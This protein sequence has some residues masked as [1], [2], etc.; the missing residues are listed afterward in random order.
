MS[1]EELKIVWKC[2][3]CCTHSRPSSRSSCCSPSCERRGATTSSSSRCRRRRRPRTACATRTSFNRA[4]A[5]RGSPPPRPGRFAAGGRGVSSLLTQ[6]RWGWVC[7]G[8]AAAGSPPPRPGRFAAGGRGVSSLLTQRRWGWVC[9]GSAAAGLAAPR[10]GRFAAGGRGV[11]SL[12]TQRRWGWVCLGSAAP[13]PADQ[14]L[15]AARRCGWFS[16]AAALC[17]MGSRAAGL[18]ARWPW[19]LRGSRAWRARGPLTPGRSCDR[20]GRAAGLAAATLGAPRLAGQRST[21]SSRSAGAWPAGCLLTPR[22]AP[23]GGGPPGAPGH[24]GKSAGGRS[25]GEDG[26]RAGVGGTSG[27]AS[28]VDVGSGDPRYEARGNR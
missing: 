22:A 5:L 6:R 17:L 27:V 12:L 8:S 10:P 4:A 2:A 20:A 28:V 15:L 13:G 1:S 9:L 3:G 19:A 14:R 7:L 24:V 11:S 16:R 21:H 23:A 18:A 26:G 25:W